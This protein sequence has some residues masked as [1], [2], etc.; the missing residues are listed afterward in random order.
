[1]RANMN[2]VVLAGNLTRDPVLRTTRAG[3]SVCKLRVASTASPRSSNGYEPKP[4]YINITIW[5]AQGEQAAAELSKGR[6]VAIDGRLE[7]RQ[8]EGQDGRR[9]QCLG[10]VAD[11]VQILGVPLRGPDLREWSPTN[12][13]GQ[14]LD[15]DRPSAE[16]IQR[17]AAE[18][19]QAPATPGF[20]SGDPRVPGEPEARAA[21]QYAYPTPSAVPSSDQVVEYSGPTS[22][23]TAGGSHA[24]VV[25]GRV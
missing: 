9:V 24:G 13:G 2:R 5:G 6:A 12:S 18:R 3:M 17:A 11:S 4:N 8:W 19:Q 25:R 15:P 20:Q 16:E 7:W 14:R 1:M 22:N 23:A 10:V 21:V